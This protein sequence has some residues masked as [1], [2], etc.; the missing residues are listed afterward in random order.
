MIR[1][2]LSAYL[3]LNSIFSVNIR[4]ERLASV[5]WHLSYIDNVKQPID[6]WHFTLWMGSQTDPDQ[7]MFGEM[8]CNGY[9][10]KFAS[11]I[12]GSLNI[13]FWNS[14]TTACWPES[15]A[16]KE[17]EFRIRMKQIASYKIEVSPAHQRFTC[18]MQAT[19]IF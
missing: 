6:R 4:D 5:V 9:E 15:D 2:I 19:L 3:A 18:L 11:P 7:M 17:Y 13:T 16:I 14:T 8:I 1:I 12:T 10:T